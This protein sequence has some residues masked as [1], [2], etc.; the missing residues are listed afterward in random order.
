MRQGEILSDGRDK[1][2]SYPADTSRWGAH[3]LA[4]VGRPGR[5]QSHPPDANRFACV[6][7]FLTKWITCSNE[8]PKKTPHAAGGTSAGSAQCF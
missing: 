2:E 7:E 6:L 1:P 5:M 8:M 4:G 3:M